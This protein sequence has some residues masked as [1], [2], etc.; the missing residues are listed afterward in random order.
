MM[1]DD[2]YPVG[3]FKKQDTTSE[4]ERLAL[5]QRLAEAPALLRHA[6]TGLSDQQL[7]TPYREGGWTVRQ[8]THHLADSHMNAYIRCKLLMTEPHPTIRPYDQDRW[9]KLHDAS[10][11]PIE[12]SLVLLESLH[13]RW[14]AFLMALA[15]ADFS[16]TLNHPESGTMKL[17]DVLQL[18]AW[19][20]RHHTA[21]ITA[22]KERMGWK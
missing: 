14:V 2:R 5:I 16:K 11:N 1:A 15:P 21:Q 18:Y 6:V 17:D 22:L 7:D 3:T 4:S 8:V 20:G 19:H 9:A 10:T 12:V 13:S